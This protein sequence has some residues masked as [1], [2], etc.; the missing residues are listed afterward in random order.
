MRPGTLEKP[1]NVSIITFCI[2]SLVK[3]RTENKLLNFRK[4]S[5]PP[6]KVDFLPLYTTSRLLNCYI[7]KRPLEVAGWQKMLNMGRNKLLLKSTYGV[8]L[9]MRTSCNKW[10]RY[11]VTMLWLY[12]GWVQEK[13]KFRQRREGDVLTS[14]QK[15]FF[16]HHN[17]VVNRPEVLSRVTLTSAETQQGFRLKNVGTQAWTVVTGLAGLAL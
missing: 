16:C 12:A 10:W 7:I 1:K 4:T 13:I 8:V 9:L 6:P 5:W 3:F 14:C 17:S 15:Y 11:F 2:C